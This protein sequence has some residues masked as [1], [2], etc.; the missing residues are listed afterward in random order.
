MPRRLAHCQYFLAIIPSRTV[1]RSAFPEAAA[2]AAEEEVPRLRRTCLRDRGSWHHGRTARETPNDVRLI[3]AASIARASGRRR[4]FIRHPAWSR[5]FRSGRYDAPGALTPPA[6]T[7][8][9][10]RALRARRSF[11]K[12]IIGGGCG[13]PPGRG[14]IALLG[15]VALR[16]V[17]PGSRR[18]GEDFR[19]ARRGS[20]RRVRDCG[21]HLAHAHVSVHSPLVSWTQKWKNR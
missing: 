17:H 18:L 12:I 8:H 16:R 10:S 6:V 2:Y 3:F 13:G 21:I 15:R 11:A 4:A 7:F 14:S 5:R 20:R 1:F 19:N 9:A